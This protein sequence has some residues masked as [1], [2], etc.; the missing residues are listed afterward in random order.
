M[1]GSGQ[2]YSFE[3]PL[4]WIIWLLLSILIMNCIVAVHITFAFSARAS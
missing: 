3:Y 2:P 4:I 1:Y